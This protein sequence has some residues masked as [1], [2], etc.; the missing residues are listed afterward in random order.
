MPHLQFKDQEVTEE[1]V[2]EGFKN[3]KDVS[4]V[5]VSDSFSTNA[6][7]NKIVHVYFQPKNLWDE[8]EIVKYAAKQ[9]ITNRWLFENL[10]VSQVGTWVETEFIDQYGKSSIRIA[11]RIILSRETYQKIDWSGMNLKNELEGYKA[12]QMVA[13]QFYIYPAISGKL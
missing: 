11:V 12:L 1:T 5:E 4:K 10:R 6:P 7:D 2:K 9:A 13:D 8:K 3:D